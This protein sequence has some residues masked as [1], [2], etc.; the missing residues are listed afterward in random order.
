MI[1][2]KEI[3]SSH[4]PT[5]DLESSSSPRGQY[6]SRPIA[7][8]TPLFFLALISLVGINSALAQTDEMSALASA[9]AASWISI[10]QMLKV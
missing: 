5:S 6:S 2:T 4:Q 9:E 10:W 3:L 8:L 1:L 7:V